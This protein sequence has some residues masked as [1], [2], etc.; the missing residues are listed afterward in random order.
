MDINSIAASA[1]AVAALASLVALILTCFQLK[2]FRFA[3]GVDLIFDLDHQFKAPDLLNARRLSAT[4]LQDHE[5]TEEIDEVLDFFETLGILVHRNAVDD[6]LAWNY[7]SHWVFRY[8]ALTKGH[9][10]TRRKDECDETYWQEFE[11]LVKRL[12]KYEKKCFILGLH[13]PFHRN[14]PPSYTQEQLDKFLA[15]EIT[16]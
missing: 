7:F 6:E 10:E 14:N 16:G 8:A 9:I 2:Q 1:A 5:P 12:T 13:L 3:H 11:F 4:A 15:Q